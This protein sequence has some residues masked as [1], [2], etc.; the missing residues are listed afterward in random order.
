MT[1]D[2]LVTI[3]KL[4][5]SNKA[6]PGYLR[7]KPD[8]NFQIFFLDIKNI[9]L[10]FPDHRVRY[11]TIEEVIKNKFFWIKIAELDVIEEIKEVRSVKY[12]LPADEIN[13]ARFSHEDDFFVGMKVS[14]NDKII[15]SV[16]DSYNNGA[17]NNLVV[18]LYNGNSM[19]I[20]QVDRYI[21][22]VNRSE[23]LLKVENIEGLMEL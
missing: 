1:L 5:N 6:H 21:I 14:Y 17:H 4:G 18:D 9:F 11:V 15:G 2:D 16:I 22:N 10:V 20:P 12:C 13:S 3:G 8:W 23:R 19:Q 7:L